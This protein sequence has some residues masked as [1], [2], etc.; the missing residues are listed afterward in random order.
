[1]VE[2]IVDREDDIATVKAIRAL[3]AREPDVL[4]VSIGPGVRSETDVIWAILR[5]LGKRIEQLAPE[6]K[7]WWLS[8]ERWLTAHRIN[9]IAVLCAQNLGARVTDVLIAHV[10][11]RLGIAVTLIYG[12][13]TRAPVVAVTELGAYLA[14]KRDQ[15]S[16]GRLPEPW[17]QVPRSHPLRFRYDCWQELT[18]EAFTRVQRPAV[19]LH[20]DARRLVPVNGPGTS[21]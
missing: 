14:R 10:C 20:D 16:A 21:T 19:R 8:A 18:P 13:P 15:L 2:V 17:P 6:I 3:A 12:R 11:G 9:E 5:A 1:M 7:V 4:A